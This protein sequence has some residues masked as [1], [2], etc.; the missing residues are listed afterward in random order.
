MSAQDYE[1]LRLENQLCFPLYACSKEI[2]RHYTPY[3]NE[4]GLT[5]TQY[6]VMLVL[7]EERQLSSK[8]L[9]RRIFLDSGTLTPLL[10]KLETKGLVKRRR[11]SQDERN[12]IVTITDDGLALRDRALNMPRI[13]GEWMRLEPAET[14]ALYATLRRL[15][16]SFRE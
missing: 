15:M 11:S 3:L 1:E 14:E 2:I 10:R 13:A 5:Y 6:I 4:I 7:W 9:G 16:D 8:E 12:L